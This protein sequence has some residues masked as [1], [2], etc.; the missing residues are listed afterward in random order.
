[1]NDIEKKEN[2]ANARRKVRVEFSNKKIRIFD[3]DLVKKIPWSTTKSF[4]NN[5]INYLVCFSHEN[6]TSLLWIIY[7]SLF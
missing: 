4:A 5:W 1:M 6:E 3:F 7:S 2:L